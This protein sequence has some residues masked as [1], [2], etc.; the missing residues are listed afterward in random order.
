M[1]QESKNGNT[2]Q[3]DKVLVVD[4]DDNWCFLTKIVLEDSGVGNQI[5]TAHNGEE[6]LNELQKILAQGEKLPELI[7]LDLK[8][9]V[10]DGFEFLDEFTKLTLWNLNQ[11]KVFISSSSCLSK[12]KQRAETYPISGF[13]TKPLTEE[14]LRVILG[15]EEQ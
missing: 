5:L 13:V 15:E 7:I 8:M 1:E 9:P 12:D 6:A 11:T 2:Q 3:I 4:D 14:N 10:M